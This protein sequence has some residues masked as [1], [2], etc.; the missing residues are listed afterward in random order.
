MKE[1][2][3]DARCTYTE[4]YEPEHTY[5][6]TGPC[7]V[8]GED[9]SVTVK[10]SELFDFRRTNSIMMLKS[11]DAGDR[12]FLISGTSPAGCEKMFGTMEE[13]AQQA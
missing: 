2:H 4:A 6:F 3:I 1:R 8:T 13:I 11:L 9:Y 7:L 12:E 5:T 10:G